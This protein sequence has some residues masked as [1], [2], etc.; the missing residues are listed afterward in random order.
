MKGETHAVAF[1]RRPA[2]TTGEMTQGR[3]YHSR[4]IMF[5]MKLQ[6]R[7]MFLPKFGL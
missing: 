6:L 1:S 2:Y 3:R 7:M 5:S 4:S